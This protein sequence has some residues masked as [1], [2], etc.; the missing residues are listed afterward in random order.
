MNS[1]EVCCL[2]LDLEILLLGDKSMKAL[3]LDMQNEAVQISKKHCR[4]KN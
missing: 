4:S 2:S 1:H 3:G